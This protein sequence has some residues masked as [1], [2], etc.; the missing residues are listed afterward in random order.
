MQLGDARSGKIFDNITGFARALRRAG[1]PVDSA[2]IILAQQAC[3]LVGVSRK[4]DLRASLRSVLVSRQEDLH[5]F[6]ELFDAFFRNPEIAKQLLTQL[7][8]QNKA[9]DLPKRSPRASEALTAPP[10][11]SG[12][13]Q[14][15]QE[16]HRLDAAMSASAVERLRHA[17][18]ESMSASE[19]KLVEQLA[20]QVPLSLPRMTSRRT[21]YGERGG[22]LHWSRLMRDCARHGGDLGVMAYLQPV[23][24]P[25]PLLILVDVSGSMERYARLMLAF[26]HQAT[27]A[28]P[29]SV[30]TFGVT[31]TDLRQPFRERD[32]DRMLAAANAKISDF[33]SGTRLGE[34]LAIFH[35]HYHQTLVARRTVVLVITDGLDTGAPELLERELAWLAGQSRYLLWLNPLLRF[36]GYQ[37]IASGAQV[38]ARHA[39]RMLAIH[40]LSRIEELAR[41]MTTLM[42]L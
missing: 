18:F 9:A 6:D 3:L 11:D 36:Q 27:R 42:R 25:L 1:L 19:F 41:A 32:T 5:V 30:F 16:E 13:V 17:D 10:S 28:A 22:R 12:A 20:R 14:P 29:R 38:L 35:R 33:A 31:L 7:L 2:R 39:H 15:K 26:L 40:N 37:P 21:R 4:E 8:P 23:R 34:S 24:R